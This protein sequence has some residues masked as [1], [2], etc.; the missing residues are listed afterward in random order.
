LCLQGHGS[1]LQGRISE[2]EAQVQR[3]QDLVPQQAAE[4]RHGEK[5][6]QALEKL[7]TQRQP[8]IEELEAR[9]PPYEPVLPAAGEAG[10]DAAASEAVLAGG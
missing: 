5:S 1:E 7:A 8:R 4:L 10:D 2:L 3:L 6:R 9:L